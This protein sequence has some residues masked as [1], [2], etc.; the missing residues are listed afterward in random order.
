MNPED[1]EPIA[2]D[3]TSARH[4]AF[5]EVLEGQRPMGWSDWSMFIHESRCLTPDGRRIAL[6]AANTLQRAL[7]DD[8][9]Q[10]T[11]DSVAKQAATAGLE[12]GIHPI[13]SLGLWP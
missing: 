1:P 11:A 9:L 4:R 6:W 5:A 7:G 8:F 12:P 10:R 13:F 2:E 3:E